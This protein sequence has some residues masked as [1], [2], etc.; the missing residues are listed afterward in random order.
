[1]CLMSLATAAGLGGGEIVVPV[2]KILFEFT[3]KDSA[4]L[5]QCCIMMA[6]ITR[7]VIN[8]RKKHPYKDAVAIEY[9]AA[10]ILMPAIFLGS[11]LGVM[12]HKILPN[13]IQEF[14]LLCVLLFCVFESVKKG[15]KFWRIESQ[16]KRRGSIASQNDAEG[17]TEPIIDEDDNQ[18]ER[19]EEL[20]DEQ[21]GNQL[22]IN[23][24]SLFS[25]FFLLIFKTFM[26]LVGL[27]VSFRQRGR[28]CK[29]VKPHRPE[30]R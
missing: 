26:C 22:L 10:M 3:Q 30:K 20:E 5:S 8:Y 1:M 17:L 25:L 29:E 9:R 7:F 24:T 2:I 16:D 18:S 28:R 13:I 21:E 23:L 4:P 11:S 15:I 27:K 6:G 12:L 19:Y 14:M